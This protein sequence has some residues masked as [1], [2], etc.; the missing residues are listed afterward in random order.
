MNQSGR[1]QTGWIQADGK[2][3][4]LNSD[5]SMAANTESAA[6][7]WGLTEQRFGEKIQTSDKR[8]L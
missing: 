4:F 7:G 5:G 3:Y 2:W 6:A 1:M 8:L